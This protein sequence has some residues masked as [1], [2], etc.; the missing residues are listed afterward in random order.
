M[1]CSDERC[2]L[3]NIFF[4]FFG[5]LYTSPESRF[6]SRPDRDG[7]EVGFDFLVFGE[8]SE[9]HRQI[10]DVF[11]LREI[12][13]DATPGPMNGNL[14]RNDALQDL[15]RR[16]FK[17]TLCVEERKRSFVAGGFDGE[18]PHLRHFTRYLIILRGLIDVLYLSYI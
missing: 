5:E 7:K 10:F 18:Y 4:E 8:F 1:I 2:F 12:W 13:H 6:Q 15:E 16:F 17:P 3:E 14:G 9:N 11:P